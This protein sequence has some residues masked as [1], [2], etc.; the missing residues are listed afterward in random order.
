MLAPRVA[1]QLETQQNG[2]GLYVYHLCKNPLCV[3]PEHLL[4][5]EKADIAAAPKSK[6]RRGKARS[7]WE[8]IETI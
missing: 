1:L 8:M 5:G 6:R 4:W 7:A 2:E 3:K